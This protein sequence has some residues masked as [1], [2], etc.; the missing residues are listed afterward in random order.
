MLS[1]PTGSFQSINYAD[2]YGCSWLIVVEPNHTIWL[3]FT[4]IQLDW[5][6]Y[7]MVGI[8]GLI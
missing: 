8:I 7:I 4:E 1:H 2:N 5:Y 3:T 6:Y